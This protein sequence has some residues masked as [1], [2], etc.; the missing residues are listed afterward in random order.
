MR[1]YFEFTQPRSRDAVRTVFEAMGSALMGRPISLQRVEYREESDRNGY[2]TCFVAKWTDGQ[3]TYDESLLNT[4]GNPR[5]GYGYE[6][7]LALTLPHVTLRASGDN[8]DFRSL[9]VEFPGR[10]REWLTLR[11]VLRREL[12]EECDRCAKSWIA[13]DVLPAL[14]AR[15]REG[16]ARQYE[17]GRGLPRRRRRVAREERSRCGRSRDARQ[18]SACGD[19]GLA[20]AGTL[21]R[22]DARGAVRASLP[23]RPQQV[24]GR[25]IA[26]CSVVRASGV[27][28]RA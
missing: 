15:A 6:L 28:V 17:E 26:A 4:D 18:R 9:T 5:D 10:G 20:R 7:K 25:G 27:A 22:L 11:D 14:T 3:I 8:N 19:R 12:G 16:L 2:T 24:E 13:Y 23:A 1:L 21:W